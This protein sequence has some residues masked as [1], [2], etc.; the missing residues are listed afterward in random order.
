M[1]QQD[2]PLDPGVLVETL[3]NAGYPP[4]KVCSMLDGRI[5]YR[6]L[7]RWRK[8]EAKPQRKQDYWAVHGLAE[9]LGV[10]PKADENTDQ[11]A[12]LAQT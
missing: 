5:S 11:K 10:L 7:Y 1:K 3:A 4:Q 8:N 9:A 12:A 6:A 2:Y